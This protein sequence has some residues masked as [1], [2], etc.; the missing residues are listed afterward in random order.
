MR[1]F[2]RIIGL[3][4]L[5]LIGFGTGI[6]GL[7]GLGVTFT[8]MGGPGWRNADAVMIVSLSVVLLLIAVACFFAIR[9]LIRKL[10]ASQDGAPR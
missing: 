8:E 5:I 3:I 1:K 4:L 10:S 7:F 2:F 9:A 6:C